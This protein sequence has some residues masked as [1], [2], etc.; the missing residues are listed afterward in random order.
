MSVVR[1]SQAIS[2]DRS[3]PRPTT[4]NDSLLQVISIFGDWAQESHGALCLYHSVV[5]S[6]SLLDDEIPVIKLSLAS[7]PLIREEIRS[8]SA[9]RAALTEVLLWYSSLGEGIHT[10][11]TPSSTTTIGRKS[12]LP[13]HVELRGFI[14]LSKRYEVFSA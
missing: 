7:P 14:P 5:N 13:E 6:T 1:V 4:R 3:G 11:A 2:G 9:L 8:R 12:P 10:C